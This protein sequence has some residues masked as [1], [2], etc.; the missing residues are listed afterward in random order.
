MN[1]ILKIPGVG[2]IRAIQNSQNN[3]RNTGVKELIK[4]VVNAWRATDNRKVQVSDILTW[5]NGNGGV[6]NKIPKCP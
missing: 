6:R 1:D 5:A 4:L 3:N 2:T